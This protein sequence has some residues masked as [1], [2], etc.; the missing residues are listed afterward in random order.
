MLQLPGA[1]ALSEF[2]LRKL[3]QDLHAR[4]VEMGGELGVDISGWQLD[5]RFIHFVDVAAELTEAE[6]TDLCR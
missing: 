1:P 5:S 4:S 6:E 3:L 2:R